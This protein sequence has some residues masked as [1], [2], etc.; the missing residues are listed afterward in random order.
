MSI[1]TFFRTASGGKEPYPY[2]ARLAA[3]AWPE[4]LVV[5]TGFS[6]TVAVLAAWFWK[7]AQR[8]TRTPRRTQNRQS[9]LFNREWVEAAMAGSKKAP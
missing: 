5:P 6:K 1:A 8:D 2:Q 9:V 4:T 3:E 7:I